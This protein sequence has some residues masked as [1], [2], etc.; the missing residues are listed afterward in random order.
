[1][2]NREAEKALYRLASQFPVVGITGPRQSGKS[3]L[4]K[5]VF[6]DKKY[7]TFDDLNMRRL[8]ESNPNDFVMAF[9]DGAIIDEAQKVPE[10]F[11]AIKMQVDKEKSVPGKFILT[12]SSQFRL[13]EN[14][15]DSLAGRAAFLRLLPFSIS[16]LKNSKSLPDNPYEL[17]F[18]GQYPPLYDKDRNFIREDWYESYIDTYLD[19]DVRDQINTGNVSLFRKFVQIC[20][21]HSGQMLS[22]DGIARDVGISAPTVKNWLSMLEASF[23]IHFL[24]PSTN[25]LGKS[26][27]K[28]PKLYFV[29]SGLMCHLLRLSS[30]EELIL[31]RY[32]GAA[33]ETFAVSEMLKYRLNQAKKP[34]LTFFRDSKGFEVDTIADWNNTFV[35]EIKSSIVPEAKLS[36]NTKKYL[37]LLDDETARNVV[38]YLSDM[39]MNIDGTAYVSWRDWAEYLK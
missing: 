2:I 13:R 17:I 16:E 23:I 8:A 10:I 31:S 36:A 6:S 4:A 7:V 27:V 33:V 14:I 24:E 12:G 26:I 32:K 21:I 30:K 34:N 39:S 11:D 9:P 29:D 35:I 22:M 3:T 20:A 37:E 5:V 38:F 28:T 15:S 1:M 25:N 19:L 18:S